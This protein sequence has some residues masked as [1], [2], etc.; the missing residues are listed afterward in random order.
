MKRMPFSLKKEG[1]KHP[2]AQEE[3]LLGLRVFDAPV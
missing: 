1:R 3:W 2:Q